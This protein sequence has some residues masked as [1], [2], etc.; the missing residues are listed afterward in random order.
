MN[1]HSPY[2]FQKY[3][4]R[5]IYGILHIWFRLSIKYFKIS[6]QLNGWAIL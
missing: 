4:T 2:I 3:R 1:K 6:H 5:H